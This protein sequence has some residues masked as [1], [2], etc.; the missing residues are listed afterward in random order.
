[1]TTTTTGAALR[2]SEF[3]IFLQNTKIVI[4][5]SPRGGFEH[6]GVDTA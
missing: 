2:K 3:L 1:M 4:N 6:L 5:G